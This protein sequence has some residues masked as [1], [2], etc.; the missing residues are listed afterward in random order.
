MLF[1]KIVYMG[2]KDLADLA[3]KVTEDLSNQL[4]E[5]VDGGG[6]NEVWIEIDNENIFA[7]DVLAE[8]GFISEGEKSEIIKNETD[9]ILFY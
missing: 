6:N 2:C 1:N 9:T 3:D 8:L 7:L 4:T 5:H